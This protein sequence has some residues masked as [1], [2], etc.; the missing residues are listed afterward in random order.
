MNSV[1]EQLVL[2]SALRDRTEI[3]RTVAQALL[4]ICQADE[5]CIYAIIHRAGKTLCLPVAQ[6][7][8]QSRHSAEVLDVYGLSCAHGQPLAEEPGVAA[9]VLQAASVSRPRQRADGLYGIELCWPILLHGQVALV[10][11]VRCPQP[12]STE[13]TALVDG[14]MR[15]LGNHLS[16]L[17]YAETDTLT[18]LYN[19]KTFEENLGRVLVQAERDA[20]TQGQLARRQFGP[21]D[22]T[23]AGAGETA[24]WLGVIDIDHFKAINDT[25]GHIYGDEV[26]LLVAQLMRESFRFE[27]RLFRFGG[28]EFVVILQATQQQYAQ[29]VFDRFR[30]RVAEHPFPQVGNIT[31]SVGFTRIDPMDTPTEVVG[32]ADEALY[33]VKENGR[34][35][36]LGYEVLLAD[37][38]LHRHEPIQMEVELF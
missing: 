34:N 38:L 19:R 35:G 4:S 32:R 17:D 13:T 37:G 1:I 21:G 29:R 2:V 15:Y 27:D 25:W 14:A 10:C 28:E 24:N 12:P 6:C 26:L 30:L 20:A 3:N 5:A 36:T 16:L 7:R 33:F 9:C 18:G 22:D 31:L 8:E 11:S 23:L